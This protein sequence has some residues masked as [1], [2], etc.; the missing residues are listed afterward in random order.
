M[1]DSQV[2]KLVASGINR[3][4]PPFDI[5]IDLQKKGF[6]LFDTN[7]SEITTPNKWRDAMKFH[8]VN[9]LEQDFELYDRAWKQK[10]TDDKLQAELQSAALSHGLI[11]EDQLNDVLKSSQTIA[12]TPTVMDLV[13]SGSNITREELIEGFKKL[14]PVILVQQLAIVHERQQN[15]M[16]GESASI[17]HRDMTT[18]KQ[19]LNI[20]KTLLGEFVVSD[21][22]D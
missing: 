5:L 21:T 20:Y 8:M 16:S 14:L 11:T 10:K 7:K 22:V 17:D 9:C 13:A 2:N 18:V 6:Q 1:K 4:S 19:C 3:I 12:F 15:Y